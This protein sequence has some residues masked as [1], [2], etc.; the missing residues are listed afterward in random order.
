MLSNTVRKQ[1]SSCWGCKATLLGTIHSSTYVKARVIK[2]CN[3]NLVPNLK[4][5]YLMKGLALNVSEI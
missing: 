2:N 5:I 1:G 3:Y 4:K